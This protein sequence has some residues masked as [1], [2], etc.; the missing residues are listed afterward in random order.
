LKTKQ[1]FKQLAHMQ[2]MRQQ[3]VIQQK[4]LTKKRFKSAIKDKHVVSIHSET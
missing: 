1:Q 2:K 3:I 4:L